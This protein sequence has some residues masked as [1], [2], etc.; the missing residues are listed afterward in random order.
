MA[1]TI[2]GMNAITVAAV[3]GRCIGGG[4][5]LAAACDLRVA[6]VTERFRIPEIDLGMPL[7][8]TGVPLLV[9][10]IGTARTKELVLT[11]RAV[12]AA[13]ADRIGLVNQV[14]PDDELDTTVVGLAAQLAAK[15][16][17]VLA[18]TERQVDAVVPRCPSTTPVST[19]TSTV[20][21]QRSAIPSA[22]SPPPHT[23]NAR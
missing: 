5:V 6:T 15:P 13:E 11:G 12:T 16:A 10:Q 3:H 9:R 21:P 20:S 2:A 17:H 4:V 18:T 8:W 1:E 22:A 14:V 19:P 7:F 23:S